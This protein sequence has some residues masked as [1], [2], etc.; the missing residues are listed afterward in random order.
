MYILKY[1][2]DFDK[3]VALFSYSICLGLSDRFDVHDF[4]GE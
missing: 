2:D 4:E 1:F 3:F